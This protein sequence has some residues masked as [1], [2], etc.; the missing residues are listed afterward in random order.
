MKHMATE[1]EATSAKKPRVRRAVLELT[2]LRQQV[3]FAVEQTPAK[4]VEGTGTRL[5]RCRHAVLT[6]G[7]QPA[8][9]PAEGVPKALANDHV[10]FVPLLLLFVLRCHTVGPHRRG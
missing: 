5:L 6:M 2:T 7:P 8:P 9:L 10:P 3:S 4:R 1:T